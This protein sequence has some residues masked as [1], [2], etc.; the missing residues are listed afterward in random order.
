MRILSLVLCLT[1]TLTA[2]AP[3]MAEP[4]PDGTTARLGLGVTQNGVTIPLEGQGDAYI[5][6]LVP[7]PFLLT[8]AEPPLDIVAVTFGREGLHR[9]L[10]LPPETGLFGPGTAYARE[11]GPEAAHF[12]TDP[13]CASQYYGPG[14][15]LLDQSRRTPDGYPVA[16][17]QVDSA[18]R[19][20]AAAGRL[21]VDVDLLGRI[22]PLYAVIR[23][24]A[25]DDRLILRFVG[26]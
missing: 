18:S 14:F 22:D 9:M 16:A 15:N 3:A 19:H 20:C 7:G 24:E 11:E 26:S 5:A 1:L 23:T 13:L 6:H 4:R 10:D 25:G 21:P 12:M 8:F 17:V 2:A